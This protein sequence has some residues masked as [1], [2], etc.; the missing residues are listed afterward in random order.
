L[1][2][3]RGA[4][5]E[6]EAA[7][8]LLGG[9]DEADGVA[10]LVG[11]AEILRGDAADAFDEDVAGGDA[12]AEGEGGEDGEFGAGV[13]AIDVGSGVGFSVAEGLGFGKDVS[14]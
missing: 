11:V 2:D 10:E 12:F 9:A 13:E 4:H 5:G 14:E 1:L 8:G 7:F 3:E 6:D